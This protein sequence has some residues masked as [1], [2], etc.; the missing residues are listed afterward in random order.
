M[1]LERLL[2]DT[3]LGRGDDYQ[4]SLKLIDQQLYVRLIAHDDREEIVLVLTKCEAESIRG[5]LTRWLEE[6]KEEK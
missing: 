5:W 2:V 1:G 3:E 4:Y 6:N